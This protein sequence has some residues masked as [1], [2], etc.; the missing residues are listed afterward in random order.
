[1]AWFI[2]LVAVNVLAFLEVLTSCMLLQVV[3]WISYA[4]RTM[5][6]ESTKFSGLGAQWRALEESKHL[7]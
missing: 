3:I 4:D 7:V 6:I 1:M 2:R 5:K